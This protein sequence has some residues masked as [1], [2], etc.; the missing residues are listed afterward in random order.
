MPRLADQHFELITAERTDD[1]ELPWRTPR[2][3]GELRRW[4]AQHLSLTVPERGLI[5]GHASPFEYLV[6]AF[7]EGALV[8]QGDEWVAANEEQRTA[9]CI[10][11]ANRGGGKTYLGAVATL[12]DLIFKAG[13]QVR[14]LA[15]SLEQSGRM[16]TYLGRL[17]EHPS[18]AG[19]I[20]VKITSRTIEA[21]GGADANVLAASETSIRGT[22]VQKLRCDEVDLFEP[23]LWQAAQLVT[24]SASP[25]IGPWGSHIRGSVEAL[26]TMHRPHGVMARVID[27]L[28]HDR[29][30][31]SPPLFR[32][33]VIDVL[34]ICPA[35]RPCAGCPLQS[36]CS[37]RAKLVELGTPGR[38]RPGE[39]GHVPIDDAVQL[40]SRVD[41]ITW[42]TE[43]LSLRPRRTDAVYEG[44]DP[45][46]HVV[47]DGDL[48]LNPAV[49]GPVTF[50]AAMDFG[51]RGESVVLLATLDE[52]GVLVIEREQCGPNQPLR[53]QIATLRQ[54]SADGFLGGPEEALQWIAIDPAG[55]ARSDQSGLSNFSI[56]RAAGWRV[57]APRRPLHEGLNTVR[58]RLT[59]ADGSP[60]LLVHERCR[61]LIEC[62][63]R[64]HYPE[65]NPRADEPVKDGFD[66]A[67]DALRYLVLSID[68]TGAAERKHY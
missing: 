67:C 44:F 29:R 12:L 1:R 38:R 40:K 13:V 30:A 25:L 52:Q 11:W 65:N 9:D 7:F 41:Q 8:R 55:G 58:A 61:R 48:R 39:G 62:L 46:V 59:P 53:T 31:A 16:H 34:A 3:P 50:A 33:G 15:G 18:I 23:G 54:W 20:D 26:S 10:V 64:Y 2:T 66:H 43:M 27:E 32:W 14:V 36:E 37:G 5:D 63:K 68:R 35:S 51:I 4:L 17:L 60:R 49:R 47:A 19:C 22:R 24:R 42:D 57:L 45:A 56:L 6:H 28:R 21:G